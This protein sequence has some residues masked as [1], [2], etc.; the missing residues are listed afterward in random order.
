MH[1]MPL[2][3]YLVWRFV[4]TIGILFFGLKSEPKRPRLPAGGCLLASNHKSYLDPPFVSVVIFEAIHFLAKSELFS[5]PLL[6][7]LIR[8]LGALPVR[9]GAVD[10]SSIKLY[11]RALKSGRP[12]LIF[13]EG[14]RKREPGFRKPRA[15]VAFLARMADV[16]VVPVYIGGTSGWSN[17][18]L[19]RRTVTVRFGDPMRPSEGDEEA[20]SR[21]VMEAIAAMADPI[22]RGSK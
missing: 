5:V 1:G 9:R 21:K 10:R 22:D 19:R 11:V 16:P 12:V 14:T 13:P 8:S 4:R 6:G 18:L 20:F 2:H 17:A 15:G 3:Y 7:P